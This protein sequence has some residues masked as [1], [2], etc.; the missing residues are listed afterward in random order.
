MDIFSWIPIE[1]IPVVITASATLIG[2]FFGAGIAQYFSHHLTKEREKTSSNRNNY[3][4]LYSP[5]LLKIFM[6]YRVSTHYRKGHDILPNV[7]EEEIL[8]E[9]VDHIGSNLMYATP[10]IISDYYNVERYKYED[11][12]SGFYKEKYTLK[13]IENFLNEICKFKIFSKENK[14]LIREYR[15]KYLIWRILTIENESMIFAN[16]VLG[17]DF[18]FNK[19][20][21]QKE[22][23]YRKIKQF[24]FIRLPIFDKLRQKI[25]KKEPFHY[26]LNNSE[27][28]YKYMLR[29]IAKKEPIDHL[30][31]DFRSEKVRFFNIE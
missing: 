6:F 27:F 21:L 16:E 9:I 26:D 15:L 19:N 30:L 17:M 29:I 5:I 18:Y 7:N 31:E 11:D 25:L 4:K 1:Y 12:D 14:K 13:L 23:N 20:E 2:A 22:R 3:Q 28:I 10:R 24:Y 8:K